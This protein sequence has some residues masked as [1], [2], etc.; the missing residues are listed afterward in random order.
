MMMIKSENVHEWCIRTLCPNTL[1]NACHLY[2]ILRTPTM[3]GGRCAMCSLFFRLFA[4]EPMRLYMWTAWDSI[5][6]VFGY[7]IRLVVKK[8]LW[9]NARIGWL[10]L[11][12]AQIRFGWIG[13][14]GKSHTYIRTW[15]VLYMQHTSQVQWIGNEDWF[16][17]TSHLLC[18]TLWGRIDGKNSQLIYDIR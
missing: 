8:S 7:S 6:L 16:A 17:A 10:K 13:F 1:I 14:G 5:E 12:C 9:L 18:D 15:C 11:I 3:D 4:I 2:R